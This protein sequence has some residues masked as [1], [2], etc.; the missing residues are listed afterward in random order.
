[1][2]Y[3]CRQDDVHGTS[4]VHAPWMTTED[5]HKKERNRKH[6]A[7]RTNSAVGTR[8]PPTRIS[9]L[10]DDRRAMDEV[11]LRLGVRHQPL[12]DEGRQVRDR[13]HRGRLREL[14]DPGA[15]SVVFLSWTWRPGRARPRA[16]GQR[17]VHIDVGQVVVDV[18][19]ADADI[20]GLLL[21]AGLVAR[22]VTP[23][24]SSGHVHVG[25]VW[26]AA[27]HSSR[28]YVTRKKRPANLVSFVRRP[29]SAP[30]P[31]RVYRWYR[32]GARSRPAPCLVGRMETL[33]TPGSPSARWLPEARNLHHQ[34]S[35]GRADSRNG[36]C[37]IGH[38]HQTVNLDLA[39]GD[40]RERLAA[41]RVQNS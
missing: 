14:H 38:V 31:S 20:P 7:S 9:V 23:E 16:S 22:N 37:K 28:L 2:I 30:S 1:M 29:G 26:R 36:T 24:T 8:S 12:V 4:N 6:Q 5:G 13:Q 32:S 19:R 41:G 17:R 25:V 10:V 27:A 35:E 21:R 34:M 40:M 3:L 15:S 11:G 39:S 33:R 18:Q